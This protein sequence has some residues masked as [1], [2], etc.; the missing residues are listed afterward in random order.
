MDGFERERALA[1]PLSDCGIAVGTF[2]AG[3]REMAHYIIRGRQAERLP[4]LE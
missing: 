3:P 2:G 1:S 4:P